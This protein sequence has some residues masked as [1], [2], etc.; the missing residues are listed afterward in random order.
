M[1]SFEGTPYCRKH[2]IQITRHGAIRDRTIY[3]ANEY[4]IHED[5]VE[6]KCFDKMVIIKLAPK[7]T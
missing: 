4:V 2:Y 3:D 1:A 6:V 7:L 5:Y